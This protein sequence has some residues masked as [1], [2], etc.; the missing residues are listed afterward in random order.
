MILRWP[1]LYLAALCDT[2]KK[3]WSQSSTQSVLGPCTDCVQWDLDGATALLLCARLK[4]RSVWFG[5]ALC[6]IRLFL[7]YWLTCSQAK[8]VPLFKN[9]FPF[10]LRSSSP[11]YLLTWFS[12]LCTALCLFW[13]LIGASGLLH[14]TEECEN[15][16]FFALLLK[17]NEC[18]IWPCSPLSCLFFWSQPQCKVY[19]HT[20]WQ[21]CNCD[22]L[23]C[24][25][26]KRSASSE[27]HITVGHPSNFQ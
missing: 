27:L 1:F 17:W 19:W 12:E 3:K 5:S 10:L 23:V 25:G 20:S 7:G 18:S 26:S 13:R 22:W 11:S 21:D 6:L 2:H 9:P 14:L 15:C 24:H 4:S 8:C 16:L